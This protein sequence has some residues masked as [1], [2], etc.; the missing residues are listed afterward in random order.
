VIDTQLFFRRKPLAISLLSGRHQR[1]TSLEK[2][3]K[4]LLGFSDDREEAVNREFQIRLHQEAIWSEQF[5]T[6]M[7][8]FLAQAIRVQICQAALTQPEFLE[9]DVEWQLREQNT[10]KGWKGRIIELCSVCYLLPLS[11]RIGKKT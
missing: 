2:E 9:Q 1:I 7:R 4:E 3:Q 11:R 8:V 10:V 6:R 5:M